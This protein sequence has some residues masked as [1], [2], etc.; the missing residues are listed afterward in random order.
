[1]LHFLWDRKRDANYW[2]VGLSI[3]ADVAKGLRYCH[4]QSVVHGD[5]KNSNVLVFDEGGRPV[6]KLADFGGA[7]LR[8]DR[9]LSGIE[10]NVGTWIF[11]PPESYD[12]HTQ[13][14]VRRPRKPGDVYA[15]AM[16][17]YQAASRGFE[18]FDHEVRKLKQ[19]P[20][21]ILR[22]ILDPAVDLRPAVPAGCG[23]P[24]ALVR[25]MRRCWDRDP[26][27]RPT[28]DQIVPEIQAIRP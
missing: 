4:A 9:T 10:L 1:M 5:L 22:R 21:G 27:A 15:F 3:L 13:N 8:F 17:C 24:P 14:I 28:F 12:R 26:A 25:L 23:A 16:L 19:A 11:I 20:S 2:E 7:R 6:A 18:P